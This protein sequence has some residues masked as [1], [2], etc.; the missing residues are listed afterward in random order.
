[1]FNFLKDLQ[2]Q[3]SKIPSIQNSIDDLTSSFKTQ[4]I[5]LEQHKIQLDGILM[6]SVKFEVPNGTID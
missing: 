3:V 6:F 5:T 4:S 2:Q 1:M